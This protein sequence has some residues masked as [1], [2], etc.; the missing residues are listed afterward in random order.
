[1]INK[2]TNLTSY[3]DGLKE[4]HDVQRTLSIDCKSRWNSTAH[5][6][7]NISKHKALI[8]QLHFDK[9]GLPLSNQQKLKLGNLELSSDEWNL[10]CSIEQVLQPF[11]HATNLMSG[12]KY[13]TIGTA[14][15]AIRKIIAFFEFYIGNNSFI[16]GMKDLL[17]E[18]LIK[19]IDEDTEQLEL[20]VVS[21]KTFVYFQEDC[22][23]SF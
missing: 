18:Q 14:L 20:L 1:M 22:S 11:H 9:H 12:Q 3:I 8:G 16:N 17:V 6:I 21:E 13:P 19:Y 23:F 10:L 4:V 5:M 15:F 7:S 2:S